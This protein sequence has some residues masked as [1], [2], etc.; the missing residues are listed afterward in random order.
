VFQLI[1]FFCTCSLFFEQE[2]RTL[3]VHIDPDISYQQIDGFGASDAWRA[4]FVGKN[5]PLEKREQIADLLFSQEFDS[6][7]NPLGIGLS[8]W[9]FYL[10]AGTAEQGELSEIGSETNPWRRGE[11]FLNADGSYDWNK[12]EGQRWFLHAAKERGVD[13]FLVF[14]NSPPVFF[15]ANGK[16]FA[17]KGVIQLNLK[18]GFLDDYARYMADVVDHFYRE[19]GIF[20]D[21]L[22]PVN[23]PQWDWDGNSQ[24]GTPALN[25]E[26]YSMV[27]YL[28]HELDSRGLRTRIIIA[29]AG[30]IGHAAL[31]MRLLGMPADGRDD[32]AR[33]FFSEESPFYIGHLPN[34]ELTLSAHSYHSVWPIEEQVQNR[35]LVNQMIRKANPE[36]GYWMSE[37]CILQENDEIGRGHGRD[38][39]MQ[40]ALYVARILHHDMV[41]TNASSWQWWT[42]ISQVDFKDG[43]VYLDD[44]SEGE[45][46]K[47][48]GHI[49]SLQY[50]GDV[51][52]SKLL[53]VLGNFSRFIRPGM[54]RIKS[55]LSEEQSPENGILVSAFKDPENGGLVYVFVNQ[56]RMT[57]HVDMGEGENVWTYTTDTS[58]NMS[59]SSQL[60][61]EISLPPRSVVTVLR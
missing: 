46:G 15:T 55:E 35:I 26:I 47:M 18:P 32:Q 50:E 40:T 17:P 14:L 9:R 28:S 33:F 6:L 4:Q 21:Y 22:S 61:N 44:G 19:E 59:F 3:Q 57:S 56:S 12:F 41:L 39:G 16:G 20:F 23:E 53:W 29:E 36:L 49:E 42:A 1:I 30:T 52:E 43:L 5:W 60:P 45:G 48:G 51:R 38:L 37:Y 31:S 34:V 25:E 2:E 8:I 58:R 10:S 54:V 11:S 13:K 7:G 24:E 27:K